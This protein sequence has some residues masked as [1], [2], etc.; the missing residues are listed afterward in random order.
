[1]ELVDTLCNGTCGILCLVSSRPLSGFTYRCFDT[2]IFLDTC[3]VI[4]DHWYV[5]A[6]F[7][8]GTDDGVSVSCC[9]LGS[10]SFRYY[11]FHSRMDD[12]TDV[13]SNGMGVAS[14][15]WTLY[16]G[17]ES[18]SNDQEIN[19]EQHCIVVDARMG[20]RDNYL[21]IA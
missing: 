16:F 17:T 15:C 2:C 10:S 19:L 12:G 7:L 9:S 20:Y 5:M 4:L 14:V 11:H 6:F 8:I 13:A 18:T 21:M 3:R 1:M